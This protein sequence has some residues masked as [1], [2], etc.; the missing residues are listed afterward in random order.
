MSKEITMA[1]EQMERFLDELALLVDGDDAAIERWADALADRDEYR[2]LLHE[3]QSAAGEV[4]MAAADY[5]APSDLSDRVLA[6]IDARAEMPLEEENNPAIDAP[7]RDREEP[8][9]D[10]PNA[11]TGAAV[12]NRPAE[13]DSAEQEEEEKELE[14]EVATV[15]A[16]SAANN[17]RV[18]VEHV[19]PKRS[20]GRAGWLAG[21][22]LVAAAA[23]ALL[24]SGSL[25]D[26]GSESIENVTIET[27][28]PVATVAQ[29]ARVAGATGD[30]VSFEP[31]LEDGQ[32]LA[33]TIVRTDAQT[34]TEIA[35][36]DGSRLVLNQDTELRIG[37]EERQVQLR[38]G[39][40]LAEV[41][42]LEDAPNARFETPHGTVEVIGT[43]FVLASSE[44]DA[45]VRVMRGAVRVHSTSG[46]SEEVK[47]G[48][49]GLMHEGDAPR[50]V[51][52]VGLASAIGW[53]TLAEDPSQVEEER[54]LEGIGELRAHRPGEREEQERPLTLAHHGVTVRVAGNVARTTISET[55]RNDSDEVLEGV[56]RFPLPA[57]ARIASLALKVDGRWEEGA[58]VPKDRARR[59]WRGVIRNATPEQRRLPTEEFI[60]VPGPWR[61]PALL[62]WQQGGRFE[63]RIF[64]IPANGER[65]IRLTYEQNVRPH[66][67]GRRYVYPMAHA[68][69]DSTRV[70]H[71]EVDVRVAGQDTQAS[72]VGYPLVA[73]P[74]SGAQRFHY[75]SEDFR[76]AGDL[77]VD[78]R[79]QGEDRELRWWTFGQA[80]LPQGNTAGPVPPNNIV[81]APATS[82]R[83]SQEV[84]R[85]QRELVADR[86]GYAVFALRPELPGWTERRERDY[87][88]VVDSSQSMV[89][90]RYARAS[91]LA[92]QMV[93]EMDRRDRVSVVTC[94]V[95]CRG[96]EE[97]FV[98]PNAEGVAEVQDFLD[99]LDPAGASDL[100]ANLRASLNLGRALQGSE[101]RELHVVYVGDGL[102][103]VGHRRAGSLAAE[104]RE[105]FQGSNGA[106]LTTVGI[107][108]DADQIA[109]A[110]MARAGGGSNVPF[111]PGQPTAVAAM[112]VL[113]STYGVALED[114]EIRL[115]EGLT[116]TAPAEIATLVSGREVIF[117]ARMNQ[118]NVSGE[119]VLRGKVGGRDFEQRYPV[120][121]E[122]SQAAG[123]AFVPRVWAAKTIESLELGGRAEDVDKVVALS[124]GYA[125]MSRHT[126]LL[127]L[128]SEAMFRAF[129]VD[130]GQ[131]GLQWTGEENAE[132]S[133]ADGL[134]DVL[135]EDL[136][137][138]AGGAAGVGGLGLSGFG[139]GAGGLAQAQQSFGRPTAGADLA[140][141][142]AMPEAEPASAAEAMP[143]ESRNERLGNLARMTTATGASAAP[144]P[145]RR[146]RRRPVGIRPTRI[147]SGFDG[148]D[149]FG[150]GGGGGG[151]VVRMRRVRVLRGSVT[152]SV[153]VRESDRQ[154]VA[155]AEA[156]L[157]QEPNSRDRHRAL[158]R[159]LSRAGQ[160]R[161]AEEVA[162]DWVSRD[163]LD[164]E[165]LT[166][167]SDV[168]GRQGDRAEALRLL[169]GIVDLDPE[170]VVLQRRLINAYERAGKAQRACAHRV[171]LV[172][173]DVTPTDANAP[174]RVNRRGRRGA[175]RFPDL[176]AA[177]RC[178][179]SLGRIDAAGRLLE[180]VPETA[181]ENVRREADRAPSPSGRLRGQLLLNAS[182]EGAAD[183][184]LSI[185]TP[186]GTRLSWMGGRVNVVGRDATR[187][188]AESLGLRTATPGT[189]F[190]EVNR[191]GDQRVPVRGTV[192]IEVLGERRR[193]PFE[194]VG[195]RT[196]IA[197][198]N[199]RRVW[200]TRPF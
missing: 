102:A 12:E 70:G 53:S 100:A 176:A 11:A 98:T 58:F 3:A 37:L 4:E 128:E 138:L 142:T 30:G 145:R 126:S 130:R 133:S 80:P 63:L 20:T 161:R 91:R 94:D 178:E 68:A 52:A 186:Q 90:E 163:R 185:I 89:G 16:V 27:G 62:E 106:R 75:S 134:D 105:I 26:E 95:E 42:H 150:G 144:R 60:W 45:S 5:V 21:G 22:G 187:G 55:F 131:A 104:M 10:A 166:Y 72:S 198:V 193:V 84:A 57:D 173:A 64:P 116:D 135:A 19:S 199:V 157:A 148:I 121:I 65:E 56:Y 1:D 78:Y 71:F 36:S 151:G 169:S 74:D 125:V 123:N 2:D 118:P 109:L 139:R 168:V 28:A 32:I 147:I 18:E 110:A 39:E 197:Q 155:Q 200:E 79:T 184:D 152:P 83:E 61:D 49:E 191:V 40:L 141:A 14:Q 183:V 46:Q 47:T 156:L 171:A 149:S 120:Q 174:N 192:N 50:V 48:Q 175:S 158:V 31:A 112:Q 108:Q 54:A 51:P 59:I 180:L 66:G 167:L 13:S 164:A 119:I 190:I 122:A 101:A 24:F 188:G 114:V 33:G 196:H 9:A 77:I 160:L 195:E 181:H 97:G 8:R 41:A 15:A 73:T 140:D 194:L 189:Y 99:K 146:A 124:R 43:K 86:R 82:T 129:G 103:T 88:I 153:D 35:L 29:T 87:L 93:T 127:V 67:E 107:G 162:R 92:T 7:P 76:P 132:E 111:T 179:S 159:A 113:E 172:E 38:R 25:S 23:A 115:P 182:W 143:T 154:T 136:N 34:R 96:M 177:M 44:R 117:A 165:A 17:A 85:L 6:A 69:D 81:T 170:S 137:Q